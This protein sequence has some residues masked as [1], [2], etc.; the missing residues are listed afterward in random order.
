MLDE[1]GVEVLD[2][3]LRQLHFIENLR[4]L[5]EYEIPALDTELDEPVELLD[6]GELDVDGQHRRPL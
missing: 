3:L 6:V 4:D 2:L 5:V 1:V